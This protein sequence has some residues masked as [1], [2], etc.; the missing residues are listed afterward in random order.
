ML[1][2]GTKIKF[3]LC[4][5]LGHQQYY[6]SLNFEPIKNTSWGFVCIVKRNTFP[7]GI[8]SGIFIAG[9]KILHKTI[10]VSTSLGHPQVP[11][12]LSMGNPQVK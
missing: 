3:C 10:R 11:V 2:I 7:R 8:K 6:F 1:S 9:G 12:G 4:T 5:N